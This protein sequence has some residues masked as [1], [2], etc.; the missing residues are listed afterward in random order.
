MKIL[1]YDIETSPNLAYVWG[2]YDQ[3]V[4]DFKKEWEMLSFAYK[5]QGSD[6]VTCITRPHFS[7]PTD[8][9]LVKALWKLLD[10]ADVVIAHNGDQFDNK[11]TSARFVA[12]GIT[13]P[14]PYQSIDTKKVAKSYFN[15]NSNS[16]DDLGR[17]L[18]LGRKVKH[19]GFDMWLGCMAGKKSSWKEMAHYNKQ[20]VVL[21]EKVYI[22]MRCWINNHPTASAASPDKPPGC[23]KCGGSRLKSHGFRHLKTQSYQRYVCKDCGGWCRARKAE[24]GI[25]PMIVSL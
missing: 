16:L 4:I 9:S 12:H 8:K 5:W 14:S 15:F 24:K 25:K 22:K 13:P 3:N 20:D 10:E 17:T 7:D 2:K 18:G 19:S 11:K 23:P 6:K 1:F 21:L